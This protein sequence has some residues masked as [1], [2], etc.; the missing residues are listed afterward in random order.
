MKTKREHDVQRRR[1]LVRKPKSYAFE[2]GV[3]GERDDEHKGR[4]AEAR[5]TSLRLL[6]HFFVNDPLL[7]LHLLV[8][9]LRSLGC[10]I[11]TLATLIIR[12]TWRSFFLNE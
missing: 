11:L 10:S 8:K 3:H 5:T 4:E 7:R 9:R 2:D 6:C 12:R 1:D